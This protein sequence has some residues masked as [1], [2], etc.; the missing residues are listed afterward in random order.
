MAAIFAV[1]RP[2]VKCI[3]NVYKSGELNMP[4]CSEMEQVADEMEAVKSLQ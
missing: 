4:T 1:Q 2:V 3:G